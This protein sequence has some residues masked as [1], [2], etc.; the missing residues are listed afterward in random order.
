MSKG[1]AAPATPKSRR[2]GPSVPGVGGSGSE[3]FWEGV[4]SGQRSVRARDLP[5]AGAAEL[6]A[7]HVRMSLRRPRRDAEP[8][9][10]LLVRAPIGDQ[11]DHLA[12]PFRDD[13]RALVQHFDHGGDANNGPAAC[14]LV[15]R[16]IFGGT[17]K[18]VARG[19]T[20]RRSSRRKRAISPPHG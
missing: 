2:R 3:A 19:M 12:L 8:A 17:P 11:L 20:P 18:G 16:R 7:E 1:D 5:A 13:R 14:L 15:G 9:S 4:L 6:L 10:D